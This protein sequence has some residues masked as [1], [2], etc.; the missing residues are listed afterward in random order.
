MI[1]VE[2]N[3]TNLRKVYYARLKGLNGQFQSNFAATTCSDKDLDDLYIYR[4]I[5]FPI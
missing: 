1:K 4:S 5:P 3:L 2:L